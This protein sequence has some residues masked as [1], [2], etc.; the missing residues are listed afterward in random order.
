[1]RPLAAPLVGLALVA[2]VGL[3]QEGRAPGPSATISIARDGALELDGAPVGTDTVAARLDLLQRAPAASAPRAPL[4]VVVD[5]ARPWRLALE[6]IRPLLRGGELADQAWSVGDGPPVT[7]RLPVDGR[8]APRPPGPTRWVPQVQLTRGE[9]PAR[10]RWVTD[11]LDAGAAPP[12]CE[13]ALA[14][15]VDVLVRA[16]PDEVVLWPDDALP[17]REAHA[18][19]VEIAA[20]TRARLLLAAPLSLVEPRRR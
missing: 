4:R 11:D 16:A 2:A 3:A 17:F 12:G 13:G 9:P 1:M 10:L 18:A 14:L 20:R 7:W 15:V 8:G 6:A 19:A 5:G